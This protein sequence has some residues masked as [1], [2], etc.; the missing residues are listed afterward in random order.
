MWLDV[1]FNI[2]K[3]IVVA[4]LLSVF[5]GI[6]LSYTLVTGPLVETRRADVDWG[7]TALSKSTNMWASGPV[8]EH[9]YFD[10]GTKISIDF[11][12]GDF[13]TGGSHMVDFFV[14]DEENYHKW[15]NN[16]A[17]KQYLLTAKAS[18][19]NVNWSIPHDDTCYFVWDTTNYD[20]A[21]ME[22][23]VDLIHYESLP[24]GENIVIDKRPQTFI[25]FFLTTIGT[26]ITVY[27]FFNQKNA[28]KPAKLS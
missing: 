7:V 18:S 27:Y 13:H 14:M 4:L 21:V 9:F 19:L 11:L 26:V 20:T 6:L 25:L 12:F 23:R 2:T 15:K 17:S 10:N 1:I 16:Q 3:P 5:S 22:L 28:P 8:I 24:F